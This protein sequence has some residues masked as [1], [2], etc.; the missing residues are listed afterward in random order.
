LTIDVLPMQL[1]QL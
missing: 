1:E